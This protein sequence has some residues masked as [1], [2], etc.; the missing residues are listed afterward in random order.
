MGGGTGRRMD[1]RREE[2]RAS[3]EG[4]REGQR[5]EDRQAGSDVVQ[6]NIVHLAFHAIQLGEK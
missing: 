3:E 2:E 5:E 4:G 6:K 1:G